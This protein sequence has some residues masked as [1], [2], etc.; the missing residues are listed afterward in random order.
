MIHRP[1]NRYDLDQLLM[2]CM[3]GEVFLSDIDVSAVE[4]MS[5]L[6]LQY[7]FI[8]WND[9]KNCVANWDVSNVV[10]MSG[11]FA[12]SDFNGDISK[13]NVSKVMDMEGMFAHS[14]FRL[15]IFPWV[16]KLDEECDMSE[17]NFSSFHGFRF[18]KIDSVNDFIF[19]AIES[20]W[21][22]ETYE[23]GSDKV[24]LEILKLVKSSNYLNTIVT[25]ILKIMKE[26]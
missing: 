10:D 25:S 20:G 11:M 2:R 26:K 16:T 15:N 23:N 14:K 13:W 5:E 1:Q 12:H 7:P 24:R 18:G 21:L 19:A 22:N 17:F 4:D 9:S 3:D 6:F 8:E